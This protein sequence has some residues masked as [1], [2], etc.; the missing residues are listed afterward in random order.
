[1]LKKFKKM[2]MV[3]NLE[4][5][6]ITLLLP[7]PVLLYL[8]LSGFKAGRQNTALILILAVISTAISYVAN[9]I[10][11][12][13]YKK[14]IIKA[15]KLLDNN[16]SD[17]EVFKK[18]KM[19]SCRFPVL[20]SGIAFISWSVTAML[21][22]DLPLLLMGKESF[23][24]FIFMWILLILT[25]MLSVSIYFLSC[26][27]SCIAFNSIKE[28]RAIQLNDKEPKLGLPQKIGISIV[29]S[30]LYP[31][32][33]L[34]C[35]LYMNIYNYIDFSGSKVAINL[36]F[37]V[38]IIL[39]FIITKLLTG[40]LK[41]SFTQ[42]NSTTEKILSGDM[43][44]KINLDLRDEMGQTVN[45]FNTVIDYMVDIITQIKKTISTIYNVSSDISA[46][47]EETSASNEE[48]TASTDVI[49]GNSVDVLDH[50]QDTYYKSYE[51]S[52]ITKAVL[53]YSENLDRST[54]DASG[55]ISSGKASVET[56][57]NIIETTVEN[58][59]DTNK[60]VEELFEKTKQIM[61]ILEVIK[62]IAK[63]TNLL[64][65]NAAIEASRAGES[66]RGF[67]VVAEEI[68]KLA[69]RSSEESKNI[70][71]VV[72]DILVE[73]DNSKTA[74][75][76]TVESINNVKNES[77]VILEKFDAISES[78]KD[79]VKMSEGMFNSA[80]TQEASAGAMIESM[81]ESSKLVEDISKQINDVNQA[82]NQQNSG[83][84]ESIK[85][86]ESLSTMANEVNEYLS[87][88]KTDK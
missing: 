7:V 71:N 49:K 50:V 19:H 18:A 79:L 75:N 48:L 62:D 3:V 11:K 5:E 35:L 76:K 61:S 64:A 44:E 33:V 16:K 54:K 72:K 27:K 53:K 40:N 69:E 36:L 55:T 24:E 12:Y 9:N 17:E 2:F 87:K 45:N 77:K 38:T 74:V 65:L 31:A 57:S 15:L 66:G 67:S 46:A 58:S 28:L 73:A 8:V 6:L 37:L 32:G 30:T 88:F 1:M 43:T 70:E 39:P 78:I 82:I 83:N 42:I 63:Q 34:G 60:T 10:V 21:V 80:K 14:P 47:V 56:M 25:G 85:A 4:Q 13:I 68:G 81:S 20:D 26:E 22:I 41:K 51:I 84:Q 23:P 29:L 86:I 52:E 59:S